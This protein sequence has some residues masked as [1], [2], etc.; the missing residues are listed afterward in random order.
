MDAGDDAV[1]FYTAAATTIDGW[2]APTLPAGTPWSGQPSADGTTYLIATTADLSG[3]S[4][5]TA[6][7]D[8]ASECAARGLALADVLTWRC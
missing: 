8:L 2:T 1:N 5:V 4:D 7:T 6:V 3:I